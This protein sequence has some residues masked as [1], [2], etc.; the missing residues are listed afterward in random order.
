MNCR[1]TRALLAIYRELK[2]NQTDMDA[3]QAHLSQCAACKV[4]QAQ[5]DLTGE[6]LRALPEIELLPNAHTKLMQALATEHVRFIQ[7]TPASTA[8]TPTPAFLASYL[9][10]LAQGLLMPIIWPLLPLPIQAQYR[11]FGSQRN[12]AVP[13]KLTISPLSVWLPHF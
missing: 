5:Y 2:L 9:K 3:L 13:I 11:L 8:A 1:Q 4:I 7:N 10:D 6:G 12:A